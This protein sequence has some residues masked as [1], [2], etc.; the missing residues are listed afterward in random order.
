MKR[1]FF[2]QLYASVVGT[3][4]LL[5]CVRLNPLLERNFIRDF[6]LVGNVVV[7]LRFR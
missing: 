6:V 2:L 4:N 5:R 7:M 3:T 1:V